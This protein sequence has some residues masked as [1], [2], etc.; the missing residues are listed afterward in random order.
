[1]IHKKEILLSFSVTED[2]SIPF[3]KSLF[4]LHQSPS[5]R[6]IRK[7]YIKCT[8]PVIRQKVSGKK[9]YKSMEIMKKAIYFHN[10]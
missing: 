5:T 9:N 10:V 7:I 6:I 4:N 2:L 8:M 1:M 3:A